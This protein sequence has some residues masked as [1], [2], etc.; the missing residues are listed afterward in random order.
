MVK[1]KPTENRFLEGSH[2][3]MFQGPKKILSDYLVP[4]LQR[5]PND[6]SEYVWRLG[7]TC[8]RHC[9]VRTQRGRE[10][11]NVSTDPVSGILAR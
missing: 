7:L 11:S 3:R 9:L 8:K 1:S 5:H 2:P 4:R 6:W 10:G